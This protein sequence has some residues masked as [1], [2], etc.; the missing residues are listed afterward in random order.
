MKL[1]LTIIFRL[2]TLILLIFYIL[3]L[4]YINF[5]I[6]EDYEYY[7]QLYK[8]CLKNK[9]KEMEETLSFLD[10]KDKQYRLREKCSEYDKIFFYFLSYLF[11]YVSIILNIFVKFSFLIN[12]NEAS[13]QLYIPGGL[14]FL[15]FFY[16]FIFIFLFQESVKRPKTGYIKLIILI[17]ISLTDIII[18]VFVPKS[19]SKNN[20]S[21]FKN[22]DCL[23]ICIEIN[24]EEKKKKITNEITTL[25][26][27]N[28]FYKEENQK[29]IKLKK[30][31]VSSNIE[32]KKIE[33]ILWYVENTY[34]E[35]YSSNILYKYI[36]EEI[37]DKFGEVIDKSK[38]RNICLSYIKERFE[39]CVACPITNG[40]FIN[41]VI[42]PEGQTFDKYNIEKYLKNKKENPLTRKRLFQ[43]Q[44]IGNTLVKKL[45]VILTSNKD[46]LSM[47]N[48]IKMKKLLINPKNNNFYSNP[49]VI[50]EGDKKGETEEGFGLVS[51]YSNKSIL[52]IIEQN[53]AIL[54]DE[55]FE[56]INEDNIN[57]LYNTKEKENVN[58]DE[59]LNIVINSI[60]I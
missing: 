54:S 1:C 17:I 56:D 34:N 58:T 23:D 6:D 28:N 14:L 31:G 57:Y 19:C 59:R 38:L 21:Q 26:K 13:C 25:E 16:I 39:E 36:L 27:N 44:L 15:L 50:K 35:K 47:D 48:F 53:K 5:G 30:G 45:C 46:E 49:V 32:D 8:N 3:L 24:N 4:L 37:K 52:N 42:T 40:I 2:L 41:P 33:V 43:A 60:N 55:F 29:L 12:G 18:L 20:D 11:V 7:L 51:E 22:Y 10:D 9:E